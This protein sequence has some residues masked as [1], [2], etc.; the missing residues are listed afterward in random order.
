MIE[1]ILVPSVGASII[2]GTIGSLNVK[3]GDL[4]KEGQVLAQLETDK[5]T[6][7]ITSLQSGIITKILAKEGDTVA[8]GSILFHLEPKKIEEPLVDNKNALTES[9]KNI[10]ISAPKESKPSFD[11]KVRAISAPLDQSIRIFSD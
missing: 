2:E 9:K 11:S 5:A 10:D 4:V 7:E 6:Q 8:I 1:H 3:E